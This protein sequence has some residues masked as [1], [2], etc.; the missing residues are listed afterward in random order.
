LSIIPCQS[1]LASRYALLQDS[2]V[3]RIFAHRWVCQVT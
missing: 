2:E 3:I 1:F